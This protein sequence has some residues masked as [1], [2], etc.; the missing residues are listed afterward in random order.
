MR[1]QP[2]PLDKTDFQWQYRFNQTKKIC[3]DS[4]PDS[5]RPHIIA[6]IND[7][8]NVCK[9]SLTVERLKK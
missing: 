7:G 4:I 3:I 2:S 6:K 1:S 8:I 5:K 9:T